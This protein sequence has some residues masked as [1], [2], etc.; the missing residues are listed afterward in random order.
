MSFVASFDK[1]ASWKHW[2][3]T[4]SMLLNPTEAKTT[5]D[6][7]KPG[8]HQL[9]KEKAQKYDID[10][11]VLKG[12]VAT[13]SSFRPQVINKADGK[14]IASQSRGL[15]QIKPATAAVLG[16]RGTPETLLK[17]EVNLEYG[18]KY[19]SKQLKRY[20]GDYEKALSAY[21]AGTATAKNPQYVKKV[22]TYA[23]KYRRR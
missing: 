1:V 15:T 8:I 16:F 13:E 6:V 12:L 3:L 10:E 9:I 5:G 2:L 23:R 4:G 22:L 20:S 11:S 14:T 18:A 17:P 7:P 21:N 19:L